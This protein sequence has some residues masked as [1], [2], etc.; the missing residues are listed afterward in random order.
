MAVSSSFFRPATRKKSRLRLAL[1]GPAGSG[2]TFTALRFAFA[3]AGPGGR[4][5]VINTESGA[6]EKYEGL[7]PD[8]IEWKFQ[9]GELDN[10]SP[11]TYTEAIQL[12]GKLGF[13]VIVIDS[14]SHAWQG[15]GGALD[16]VSRKGGNSYTAWKDVTPQHN[17]MIEAILRSPAHVIATMRTKMEYVLEEQTNRAG[18]TVQVPVKVG[19]APIQRAGMEY[20]FDVVADIDQSHTLTV[21]KTRCPL[22]DGK[23]VLKPGASFIEPVMEWLNEGAEVDPSY[24]ATEERDL[25]SGEPA[26]GHGGGQGG[27]SG[28]GQ[29][30]SDAPAVDWREA[31]KQKAAGKEAKEAGKEV[32]RL[33]AAAVP[34]TVAEEQQVAE[35]EGVEAAPFDTPAE[36]NPAQKLAIQYATKEQAIE[37]KRLFSALKT[38]VEVQIG[39]LERKGV[40]VV[41]DE[42]GSPC[43]GHLDHGSAADLIPKL[44]A[45][46]E[47]ARREEFGVTEEHADRAGANRAPE[48]ATKN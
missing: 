16:Q 2:K 23:I 30:A 28:G 20:E 41:A 17:R 24:Y 34:E 7:S 9:V 12:A 40:M 38:P 39:I 29:A 33:A 4:V 21:S 26:R 15:D 25:K 10:F 5:A 18:K 35:N 37:I 11:S 6:V 19:M 45:M 27:G 42:D 13:N 14:L 31:A 46:L 44:T 22:I 3:I 47:A 43:V 8:G 36:S 1:D 32:K 48:S